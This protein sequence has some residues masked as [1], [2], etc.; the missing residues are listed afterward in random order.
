MMFLHQ[1]DA[2]R[3]SIGHRP[4]ERIRM[5]PLAGYPQ[6]PGGDIRTPHQS[7]VAGL[8]HSV[9]GLDLKWRAAV[10]RNLLMAFFPLAPNHPAK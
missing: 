3:A 5:S 6:N 7:Q 9:P 1:R 10:T 2:A 8:P 4:Q